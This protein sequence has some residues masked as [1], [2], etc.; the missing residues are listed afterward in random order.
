MNDLANQ[1]LKDLECACEALRVLHS[2]MTK[3]NPI[4]AEYVIEQLQDATNTR[5]NVARIAGLL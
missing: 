1:A 2:E 5:I 3:T 4:G